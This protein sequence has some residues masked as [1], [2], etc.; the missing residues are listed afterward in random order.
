VEHHALEA[1]A[2][3]G[4]QFRGRRRTCRRPFSF[5][6][7]KHPAAAEQPPQRTPANDSGG[8][9]FQAG[10]FFLDA[11][12]LPLEIGNPQV[13]GMWAMDF[14]LDGC[15]EIR[16]FLLQLLDMGIEIHPHSSA[17]HRARGQPW[18]KTTAA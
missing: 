14:F 4:S 13:V 9:L 12:L 7:A 5:K 1:I 16:V 11:Q 10:D 15:F 2:R 17:L 8:A 3:F 18:S 6:P